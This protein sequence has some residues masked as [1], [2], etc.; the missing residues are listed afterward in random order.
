MQRI[1][2]KHQI[3]NQAIQTLRRSAASA[4]N[5]ND[6]DCAAMLLRRAQNLEEDMVRIPRC[7]SPLPVASY[8]SRIDH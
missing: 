6:P 7:K 5:R 2:D 1:L 4:Y 8:S 3:L